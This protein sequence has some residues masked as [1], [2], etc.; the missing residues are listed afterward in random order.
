[1]K[2]I[3]SASGIQFNCIVN[4]S[5]IGSETTADTVRNSISFAEALSAATGLPIWLHTAEKSVAEELSEI[6]M[7]SLSLQK[8]LF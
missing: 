7:L 3:E 6:P 5:N 1:M 2:G 4:N 8:K